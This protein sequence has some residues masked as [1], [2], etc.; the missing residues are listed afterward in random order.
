MGSSIEANYAAAETQGFNDG[1]SGFR[2]NDSEYSGKAKRRYNKGYNEGKA[3]RRAKS[4]TT[5]L[6]EGAAAETALADD[7]E[8]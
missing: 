5:A 1:L 3:Q 2:R 7:F 4:T 8:L 6:A